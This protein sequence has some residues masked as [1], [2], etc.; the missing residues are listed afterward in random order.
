MEGQG[1][2]T[3][4]VHERD[5]HASKTCVTERLVRHSVHAVLTWVHHEACSVSHLESAGLLHQVR[6]GVGTGYSSRG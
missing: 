5:G 2:P 3:N 4:G 6:V 1:E